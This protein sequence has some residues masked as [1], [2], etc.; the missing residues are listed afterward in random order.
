M[1]PT[2]A[3]LADLLLA[4]CLVASHAFA[5]D[6]ALSTMGK[7]DFRI[8]KPANPS[9]VDRYALT[10]LSEYLRQ[11]TGAEFSVVEADKAGGDSPCL[12]VGMSAAVSGIRWR[13]CS[14]RNMFAEAKAVI[15]S[16][17]GKAFTA[18]FMR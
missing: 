18:T 9:A 12:Y 2:L 15:F 8:V 14:T 4:I 16:S 3:L 11:I 17:M 1:K 10:K 5:A 7:T 6:L 13:R